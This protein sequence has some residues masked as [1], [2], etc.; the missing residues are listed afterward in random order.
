M[1]SDTNS[2]IIRPSEQQELQ[3]GGLQESILGLFFPDLLSFSEAGD[4]GTRRP[5]SATQPPP[6]TVS[7]F[8]KK[9]E[10]ETYCKPLAKE[11][12]SSPGTAPLHRHG[13]Y[14]QSCQSYCPEKP[15]RA[16]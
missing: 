9:Q 14:T 10:L 5:L 12:I 16:T 11:S 8:I 1:R 15:L 3:S 7:N 4:R 6:E 2:S 13:G